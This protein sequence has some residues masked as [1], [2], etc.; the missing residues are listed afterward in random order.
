MLKAL[1]LVKDM[2]KAFGLTQDDAVEVLGLG[3]DDAGDV[4]LFMMSSLGTPEAILPD[5]AFAFNL[6][7][8]V[9]ILSSRMSR[10]VLE[11]NPDMKSPY[12]HDKMMFSSVTFLWYKMGKNE[13]SK[14][15]LSHLL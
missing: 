6:S 3:Q 8:L 9:Q 13:F 12:F 14:C 2:L 1:D 15:G 4:G 10:Q 7:N 11:W 5:F